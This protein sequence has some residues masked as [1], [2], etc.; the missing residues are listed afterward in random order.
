MHKL[1]SAVWQYYKI[2]LPLFAVCTVISLLLQG[3]GRGPIGDTT[4]GV[5]FMTP[6]FFLFVLATGNVFDR[7]FLQMQIPRHTQHK[8]FLAFCRPHCSVRVQV[9]ALRN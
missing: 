9:C 1:R 7:L 4:V 3:F 5:P 2:F 6:F 8:A